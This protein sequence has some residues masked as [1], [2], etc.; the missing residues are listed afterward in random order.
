MVRLELHGLN[1]YKI[2]IYGINY[3][4]LIMEIIFIMIMLLKHLLEDIDLIIQEELI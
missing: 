1:K 3:H 4:G 2:M